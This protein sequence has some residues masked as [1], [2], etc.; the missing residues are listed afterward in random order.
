MQIAT[1]HNRSHGLFFMSYE[2]YDISVI[3]PHTG[4]SDLLKKK[5]KNSHKEVLQCT[6]GIE[7]IM[8][9]HF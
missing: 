8:S 2:F 6:A 9:T 5:K 1:R 3:K 4:V 7:A